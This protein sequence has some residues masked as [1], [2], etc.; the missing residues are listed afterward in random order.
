MIK[1]GPT[2]FSHP[3][4]IS[5]NILWVWSRNHYRSTTR[6][7]KLKPFHPVTRE[8]YQLSPTRIHPQM[9]DRYCLTNILSNTWWTQTK[10]QNWTRA[11]QEIE[12]DRRPNLTAEPRSEPKPAWVKPVSADK[13]NRNAWAENQTKPWW[14]RSQNWADDFTWEAE[15]KIEHDVTGR[16]ID[17][18]HTG[19]THQGQNLRLKR[20]TSW[21]KN[22]ARDWEETREVCSWWGKFWPGK[23]S[24]KKINQG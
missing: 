2:G 20:K 17:V 9:K 16:W 22:Q 19:T 12:A 1:I 3:T 21:P 13:E 15:G 24:G 7:R 5:S 10:R 23:L 11:T 8:Q 14:A 6:T 4:D 18:G